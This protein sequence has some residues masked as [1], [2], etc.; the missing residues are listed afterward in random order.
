MTVA[1]TK[2]AGSGVELAAHLTQTAA[3]PNPNHSWCDE[4]FIRHQEVAGGERIDA[5]QSAHGSSIMIERALKTS[6]PCQ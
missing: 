6:R 1:Q 5:A 4:G 3:A 2:V